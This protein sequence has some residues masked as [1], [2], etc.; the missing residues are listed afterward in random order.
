M[1][2]PCLSSQGP[3]LPAV[4]VLMMKLK[5][6]LGWAHS[7]C[8]QRSETNS[9]NQEPPDL[10]SGVGYCHTGHNPCDNCQ[11][12]HLLVGRSAG[13]WGLS[14]IIFF[15]PF[16]VFY[17]CISRKKTYFM[18]GYCVTWALYKI[19]YKMKPQLPLLGNGVFIFFQWRWWWWG[20]R[21]C[22]ENIS[23]TPSNQPTSV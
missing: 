7:L 19:F 8:T 21:R 5:A 20:W 18:L 11:S 9:R 17:V 1:Y 22:N 10:L 13:K 16:W 6:T 12:N 4:C 23:I 3:L 14:T 15:K 2:C